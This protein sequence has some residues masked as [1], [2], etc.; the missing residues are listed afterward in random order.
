M[1]HSHVRRAPSSGK[2]GAVC[3]DVQGGN[4]LEDVLEGMWRC[5][6][7]C[8][9][10]ARVVMFTTEHSQACTWAP[11]PR[12]LGVV[13]SAISRVVTP[14]RC[15]GWG[16][17]IAALLSQLEIRTDSAFSETIS[18][19]MAVLSREPAPGYKRSGRSSSTGQ[20]GLDV[21]RASAEGHLG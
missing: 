14:S 7:P 1:S 2:L 21:Q 13:W 4:T 18:A 5:A 15:F 3:R 6:Y 10:T 17:F 16:H 19:H 8:R 12:R 9:A 20:M 11:S